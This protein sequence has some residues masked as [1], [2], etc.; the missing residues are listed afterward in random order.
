[1]SQQ[2]ILEFHQAK[3]REDYARQA[4]ALQQAFGANF[5]GVH[6]IGSTAIPGIYA[7]PIIDILVEVDDIDLVDDCEQGLRQ[8]GYDPKGEYG[9]SGR[10]Y[11][12][13]SDENFRRTHHMHV[14]GVDTSEIKR[15]LGFRDFLIAHPT[16]A[17]KYSELKRELVAAYDGNKDRYINGKDLFI[18]SIDQRVTD[19]LRAKANRQ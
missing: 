16:W 15:H 9:I 18:K 4:D 1:M 12:Q 14:F 8:L 3:W 6:H 2:L 13:K 5:V 7:K 19:W 10:R 17:K 11:F